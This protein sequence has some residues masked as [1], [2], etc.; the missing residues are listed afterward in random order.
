M[1]LVFGE[2]AS[3]RCSSCSGDR[4]A[5]PNVNRNK[6]HVF[7]TSH[8]GSNDEKPAKLRDFAVNLV[9]FRRFVRPRNHRG[10]E[11]IQKPFSSLEHT[12]EIEF[13]LTASPQSTRRF[14]IS[15]HKF[16]DLNQQQ[17]VTVIT[18]IMAMSL[19]FAITNMRKK[20]AHLMIDVRRRE[21]QDAD[22]KT[23]SA[24]EEHGK[25]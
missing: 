21:L 13:P 5:A 24:C 10:G 20:C 25:N 23:A 3:S 8:D 15:C 1:T 4:S 14:C 16:C 19:A 6:L 2:H 7:L 17:S 22:S 9:E 12:L 18:H 11:T